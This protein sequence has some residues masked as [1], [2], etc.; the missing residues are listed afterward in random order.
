MVYSMFLE[1][2]LPLAF[3]FNLQ[4]LPTDVLLCIIPR[5]TR[6]RCRDRHLHRGDERPSEKPS[7]SLDAEEESADDRREDDQTTRR[8]HLRQGSI[9]GNLN[10]LGV[11]LRLGFCNFS[12][13]FFMLSNFLDFVLPD[14][15]VALCLLKLTAH[16]PEFI[17]L[18]VLGIVAIMHSFDLATNFFNHRV[19]GLSDGFHSHC[20]EP[21][22]NH[23]A[24]E[25][26]SELER[27]EKV[28]R[29]QTDS[30][31]KSSEKSQGHHSGRRDCET[32]ADSSGSISG[33]VQK[34]CALTD[35]R[36]EAGHFRNT[37]GI[38]SDRSIGIDG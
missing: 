6:V 37:T 14:F 10:A 24:D 32:F 8:D 21:V 25:Q 15:D 36:G 16:D 27:L 12:I 23:C 38:V 20:A 31:N 19:S 18:T 9:S 5:S 4:I 22:R 3:H 34:V 1:K 11:L 33:C 13:L 29:S 2:L 28:D 26:T 17:V 7:Q 35:F 30:V